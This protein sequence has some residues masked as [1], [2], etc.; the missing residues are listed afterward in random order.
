MTIILI[1]IIIKGLCK[2]GFY[3]IEKR[4]KWIN[5][6]MRSLKKQKYTIKLK[7]I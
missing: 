7:I 4:G 2:S 6:Y 3:Y 5:S 1:V